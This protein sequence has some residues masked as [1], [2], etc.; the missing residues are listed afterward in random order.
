MSSLGGNA[1][2]LYALSGAQR[3]ILLPQMAELS[4][5]EGDID[6][7]PEVVRR[8]F[9]FQSDVVAASMGYPPDQWAGL[10]DALGAPAIEELYDVAKRLSGLGKDAVDEAVAD[11]GETTSA[12]SGTD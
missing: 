5:R 10:A 4:K 9:T 6:N 7:D 11:L 2:R 8:V 1:V 12:G 3:S